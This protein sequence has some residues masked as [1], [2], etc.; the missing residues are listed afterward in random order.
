MDRIRMKS[1]LV[2]AAFAAALVIAPGAGLPALAQETAEPD[3]PADVA[4]AAAQPAP[5]PSPC[6]DWR[7][8]VF[9]F[10]VGDWDV[11]DHEGRYAGRNLVSVEENGCLVVEHWA[12]ANGGTGQSYSY[13]DPATD[14]WRQVWISASETIDFTGGYAED[15][16]MA[17]EGEITYRDGTRFPFRGRWTP[18]RNGTVTQAF[19]QFDPAAEAW[20]PWFIG[21]YRRVEANPEPE[22]AGDMEEEP[23]E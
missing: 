20:A 7:Y 22:P 13:F 2:A 19:E 23:G 18:N 5:A 4:G 12:S 14:A 16:G 11:F 15:G 10:W 1:V 6:A 9:D 21:I 17:L 3:P 8:R